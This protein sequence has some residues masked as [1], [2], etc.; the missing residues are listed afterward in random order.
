MVFDDESEAP[1]GRRLS[2]TTALGWAGPSSPTERGGPQSPGGSALS[3][4]SAL[5]FPF[6]GDARPSPSASSA[7]TDVPAPPAPTVG[8]SAPLLGTS[9]EDRSLRVLA[10]EGK[11]S[12][13]SP[14][15]TL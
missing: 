5:P 4:N 12:P 13:P 7:A 6:E 3:S 1:Q 8:M 2:R 10:A 11:P 9:M 15:S 14:Q